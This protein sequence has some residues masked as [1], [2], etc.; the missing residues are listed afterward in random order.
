LIPTSVLQNIIATLLAHD[1]G[2]LANATALHVHLA[3]NAF[4]PSPDLPLAT[5]VEADFGGYAVIDPTA[6]NQL[7]YL[8][9]VTNLITVELSQPVGGWH[10][11]TTS[12][13]NLPQTIYG[14]YVTDHTDAVLYGS[15]LLDV[16]IPLTVS[17]QGF[18]LPSLVFAFLNNS[19]Q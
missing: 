4:V 11:Q 16:P 6:G 1:T 3:K 17:G 19:P 8:N 15:G 18:D 14:W 7:V 13:S 10:F 2:S 12:T 5:L 9:P